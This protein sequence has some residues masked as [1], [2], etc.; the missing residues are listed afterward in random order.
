[1]IKNNHY[2]WNLLVDQHDQYFIKIT[3]S[4][5]HIELVCYGGL[6]KNNKSIVNTSIFF[7]KLGPVHIWFS[8]VNNPFK[9]KGLG[10]L[11]EFILDLLNTSGHTDI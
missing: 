5:I 3:C 7:L 6:E 1:M 4:L 8:P 9:I 10:M 2:F 11:S